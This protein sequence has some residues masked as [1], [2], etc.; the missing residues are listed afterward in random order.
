MEKADT[1]KGEATR[2]RIFRNAVKLF[3]ARGY[4]GVSIRAITSASGIKESTLY[5]YFRS[6]DMLLN[7]IYRY[8][9]TGLRSLA[10]PKPIPLSTLTAENG[11]IYLQECL[12][13]Y[14]R[15]MESPLMSMCW[16]IVT[17]EQFRDVRAFDI[18]SHEF[19]GSRMGFYESI[20]REMMRAKLIRATDPSLLAAEYVYSFVGMFSEY[21]IMKYY[22]KNTSLVEK[23]MHEHIRFFWSKIKGI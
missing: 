22:E 17:M 20:F 13:D 10:L 19:N 8:F 6:K 14:R 7:E 15:L 1:N 12:V 9:T 18:I 21:N 2:E 23:R 4:S 11:Y 5:H 16:R 3:S